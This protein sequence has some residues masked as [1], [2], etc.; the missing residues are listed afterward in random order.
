MRNQR[1]NVLRKSGFKLEPLAPISLRVPS[2]LWEKCAWAAE[3]VG[4][5]RTEFVRNALTYAT[6]DSQPPENAKSR[7]ILGSAEEWAAWRRAA[8]KRGESLDSLMRTVMNKVAERIN[9]P[10]A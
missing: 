3:S 4:L 5:N 8:Q 10:M 1:R 7:M 2:E 6:K 9:G